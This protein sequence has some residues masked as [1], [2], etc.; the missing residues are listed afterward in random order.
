[1]DLTKNFNLYAYTT[2]TSCYGR[3]ASSKFFL[4][5]FTVSYMIYVLFLNLMHSPFKGYDDELF[6]NI[7]NIL[8]KFVEL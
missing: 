4:L 2:V 1:M 5:V 7:G 6:K 3:S 8:W